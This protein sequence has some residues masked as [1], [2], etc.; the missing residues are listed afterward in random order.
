MESRIFTDEE[1]R[2]WIVFKQ[3]SLLKVRGD[4]QTGNP[5]LYEIALSC[6]RMAGLSETK[7]GIP[8]EDINQHRRIWSTIWDRGETVETA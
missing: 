3:G 6:A 5:S 4:A 8:L 1:G 7:S 2:K